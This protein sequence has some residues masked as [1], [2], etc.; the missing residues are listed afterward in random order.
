MLDLLYGYLWFCFLGVLL[1][2]GQ[3]AIAGILTLI[4]RWLA[5]EFDQ[6]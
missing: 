6:K 3:L 1:I 5:G 4:I 2:G